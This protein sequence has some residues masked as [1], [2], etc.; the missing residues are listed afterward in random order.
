MAKGWSWKFKKLEINMKLLV[1]LL[2]VAVNCSK[3]TQ[4]KMLLV[5]K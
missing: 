5:I 1:I 2:Y 3:C 4:E